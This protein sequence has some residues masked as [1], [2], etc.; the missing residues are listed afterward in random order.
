MELRLGSSLE[1]PP[2][3]RQ[4]VALVEVLGAVGAAAGGEAADGLEEPVAALAGCRLVLVPAGGQMLILQLLCLRRRRKCRLV[5]ALGAPPRLSLLGGEP[6]E[7]V[8]GGLAVH[9]VVGTH[10]LREQHAGVQL[11]VAITKG[12]RGTPARHR[13]PSCRRL[14]RLRHLDAGSFGRSRVCRRDLLPALRGR[15]PPR[16]GRRGHRGCSAG[17]RPAKG[18]E[19]LPKGP[20]GGS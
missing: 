12:C 2:L 4:G 18:N 15:L 17:Q 13:R 8:A 10:E 3:R 20:I 16:C 6:R 14:L 11:L 1:R 19:V 7:L 9:A 5:G